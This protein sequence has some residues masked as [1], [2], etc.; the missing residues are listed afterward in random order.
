[1][2]AVESSESGLDDGLHEAQP[3]L[4]F[5]AAGSSASEAG[6]DVPG[7][8]ALP[9]FGVLCQNLCLWYPFGET[10]ADLAQE[11]ALMQ[12]M[13][14]AGADTDVVSVV[15]ARQ[16]IKHVLREEQDMAH[17]DAFDQKLSKFY[18]SC[19]LGRVE[20]E[21]L[22]KVKKVVQLDMLRL[23]LSRVCAPNHRCFD[24]FRAN[25]EGLQQWLKAF[26]SLDKTMRL[27]HF[28]RMYRESMLPHVDAILERGIR[29][30]FPGHKF[31]LLGLPVCRR[32]FEI[33]TC[34]G[35]G[36]LSR[37]LRLT[38]VTQLQLRT[39]CVGKV[40]FQPYPNPPALTSQMVQVPGYCEAILGWCTAWPCN[41]GAAART[42]CQGPSSRNEHS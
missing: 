16:F 34:T 27:D 35:S 21:K 28:C 41:G 12:S 5:D 3:G 31:H 23:R 19:N 7:P 40:L 9:Q 17:L 1:M 30:G 20:T 36:V 37:C 33:L 4:R 13:R 10:H 39:P 6:E 18:A 38:V 14:D 8:A 25:M 42:A 2:W 32:A 15:R 11:V 22:T 29:D 26:Y 24:P